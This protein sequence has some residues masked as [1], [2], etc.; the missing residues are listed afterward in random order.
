MGINSMDVTQCDG[1]WKGYDIDMSDNNNLSIDIQSIDCSNDITSPN[2]NIRRNITD[3]Q[4]RAVIIASVII[5]FLLLI[6]IIGVICSKK[7]RQKVK[8]N[9][10]EDNDVDDSEVGGDG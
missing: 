3:K 4:R 5:V 1:Q 10:L 9:R 8:F 2:I 6:C 7:G